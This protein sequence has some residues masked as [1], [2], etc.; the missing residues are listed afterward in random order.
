MG[1]LTVTKR[2][3]ARKKVEEMEE[4]VSQEKVEVIPTT[5]EKLSVDYHTEG[6]NNIARKINE[7]IDYLCPQEK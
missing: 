3:M 7:I 2:Y 4:D 6:L 5:I 1:L